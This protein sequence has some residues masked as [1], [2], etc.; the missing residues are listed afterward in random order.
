[1]R[2]GAL[3]VPLAALLC[4]A[5]RPEPLTAQ[6]TSPC[7]AACVA[8]LGAT[9]FV[10]ATGAAVAAGRLTGGLMSMNQGFLIWGVSFAATAGAGMALSGD[11]ERQER[12]VY[13][14]GIGTAT[15]A[16]VGGLLGAVLGGDESR[17]ITGA[18]VGAAAGALLGGVVG[19]VSS[20]D[21]GGTVPLLSLHLPL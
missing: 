14:A 17:V 8:M 11:G 5:P 16:A 20:E 21:D 18:V 3:A 13:A 7:E 19:A 10:T 6:F 15:G 9:S 4:L 12:A 1:M 2:P